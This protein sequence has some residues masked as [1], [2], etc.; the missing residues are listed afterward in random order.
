MSGTV[1]VLVPLYQALTV[2]ARGKPLMTA[3]WLAA[4]PELWSA[5]PV[6]LYLPFFPFCLTVCEKYVPCGLVGA[7]KWWL[8]VWL[9]VEAGEAEEGRVRID[10]SSLIVFMAQ[11]QLSPPVTLWLSDSTQKESALCV[12][13][14]ALLHCSA[15]SLLCCRRRLFVSY[16]LIRHYNDSFN[17][18]STKFLLSA[19]ASKSVW[20]TFNNF[21]YV[22]ES[23]L[24]LE[25]VT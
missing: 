24:P 4:G 11:T 12:W 9:L 1:S 21:F 19:V 8:S 25:K 15:F 18:R 16:K 10:L 13:P 5:S 20:A 17:D 3:R 22:P 6:P 14:L 7:V 23:G 2:G